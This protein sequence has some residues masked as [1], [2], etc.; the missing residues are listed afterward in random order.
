MT[1]EQTD[2]DG[3]HSSTNRR[4]LLAWLGAAGSTG[5]AGCNFG[6]GGGGAGVGSGSSGS[7]SGGSGGT[8]NLDVSAKSLGALPAGS[9]A[10]SSLSGQTTVEST[11]ITSNTTLG[12]D[13]DIVYL[14]GG[15]QVQG[16]V[17]LTV[18]PG[19]TVVLSQQA[20]VSVGGTLE[21]SGTC[22][23]PIAFVG[24]QDRSGFWRGISF[25]EN[26]AGTL[27][28]VLVEN[29]GTQNSAAVTVGSDGLVEMTNTEVRGSASDAVSLSASS[30]RGALASFS[31]NA[32]ADN[33]GRAV[34]GPV[35]AM[36]ALDSG[37]A[38]GASDDHPVVVRFSTVP[39]GETATIPAIGVP[40]AVSPAGRGG[41][42]VEGVL[43]VAPATTL[44]FGQEIGLTVRETGTLVADASGGDPIT[45]AGLTDAPGSWLGIDFRGATSPDNLLRN[46]EV[47]NAGTGEGEALRIGGE[48]RVTVEDSTIR[49]SQNYGV[50]IGRDTQVRSF[51][52][53]RIADNA[54]SVWA[55]AQSARAVGP[56]NVIEDNDDD[57]VH[58][59]AGEFDGHVIPEG[60][61][62][63]WSNPGVPYLLQRARGGAFAVNGSLTLSK[64]LTLEMAQSQGIYVTGELMSDVE[65]DDLPDDYEFSDPPEEFVTVRGAQE[66]AGYWNTIAFDNTQS[67]NNSLLFTEILHGG[68]GR[69]PAATEQ[70]DAAVQVLRGSYLLF[71]AASIRQIAGFGLFAQRDNELRETD[72][73]H[74]QETTAPV[75]IYADSVDKVGSSFRVENNESDF[76][77]VESPIDGIQRDLT[78]P[79]A[80]IPYRVRPSQVDNTLSINAEVRIR[81]NAELRFEQGVGVLVTR[82]GELLVDGFGDPA[83]D[84]NT[85]L[86]G[87]QASPGYWQGI[88]YSETTKADNRITNTGIYHTGSAPWPDLVETEPKRAAV[89]ATGAAEATVEEC[90]IADFEGAALAEAFT[91]NSLREDAVNSTLNLSGNVI[92]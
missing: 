52:G 44:A 67:Q 9:C 83:D 53:N 73:I 91:S 6:G 63:T 81:K 56:D 84:P 85:I 74:F 82:E 80:G 69:A 76:I 87:M 50:R 88:R 31:A 4:Q 78:W 47:I 14:P 58:V 15:L 16:G 70:K 22:S 32:L 66:T 12:A 42:A 21:A 10:Q 46:V 8:P 65:G 7:R 51:D 38:Y 25:Q 23:D 71:R 2:E 57:R 54:A 90:H 11:R 3:E 41:I 24:E 49:G 92:E 77:N 1:A 36:A 62:H 59:H 5:L 27:D 17:T 68:G 34:V 60:E 86:R 40:Y 55:S 29:A 18:E 35:T 28:H 39:D 45:V 48:T 13:S 20:S 26:G 79:N 89:A 19:T 37:T 30:P 61:E 33:E 64:G 43:E 72:F 75:Y